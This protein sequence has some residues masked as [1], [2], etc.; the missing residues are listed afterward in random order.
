MRSILLCVENCLFLQSVIVV[1]SGYRE[2]HYC[3]TPFA[4]ILCQKM[5]TCSLK[6]I[7]NSIGIAIVLRNS[8]GIVNAVLRSIG[9]ANAFSQ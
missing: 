3:F 2:M 5:C 6:S 7:C 8:V 9:I 1:V 4:R